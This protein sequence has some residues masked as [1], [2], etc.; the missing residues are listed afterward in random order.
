MNYRRPFPAECLLKNMLDQK[1][2]DYLILARPIWP[3]T[4]NAQV[5]KLSMGR[6]K[7]QIAVSL[8]LNAY[9][10]ILTTKLF[11]NVC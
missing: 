11:E 9:S 7:L 3:V 8:L 5:A 2:C 6:V 4:K 10:L 1:I